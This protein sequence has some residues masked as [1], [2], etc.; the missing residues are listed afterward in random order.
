ML[1]GLFGCLLQHAESPSR[2][3]APAH[4]SGA[5]LGP[6]AAVG[7]E[8]LLK[9][10]PAPLTEGSW[11]LGLAFRLSEREVLGQLMSW[12]MMVVSGLFLQQPELAGPNRRLLCGRLD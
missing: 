9:I 5:R 6:Q 4:S 12:A 1:R 7:T 2:A 8:Q 11:G 3:G 10:S